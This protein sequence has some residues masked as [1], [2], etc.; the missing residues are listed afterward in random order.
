MEQ[1]SNGQNSSLISASGICPV[2]HQPVLSQYYFCPNCGTKLNLT[3]LSTTIS[4]QVKIYLF[5]I[6][7]PIICFIF[8]TK[9]PGVKYF[10]SDDPKTKQIGQIACSLLIISTVFTI[11]FAVVWTQNYIESTVNSINSDLSSYS[12]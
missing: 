11:W 7:L 2:C 3:P 5:S 9:W 1:N 4:T 10:K 8:V 6:I 12:I